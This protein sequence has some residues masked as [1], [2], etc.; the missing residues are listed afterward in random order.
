VQ[1]N[2]PEKE[3]LFDTVRFSRATMTRRFENVISDLFC[4]VRKKAEE[5]EGFC[6]ALVESNDT[7]STVHS[8]I[9]IRG[10][11]SFDVIVKLDSNKSFKVQ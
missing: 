11:K 4:Q 1:G 7:N 2:F 5:F 8:L 6:L 9:V 10:I 3:T